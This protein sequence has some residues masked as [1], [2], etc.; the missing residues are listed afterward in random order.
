MPFVVT[1]PIEVMNPPPRSIAAPAPATSLLAKKAK[2]L[3]EQREDLR[4]RMSDFTTSLLRTRDLDLPCVRVVVANVLAGSREAITG[5]NP[6]D[7]TQ[8]L[9][10]VFDGLSDGLALLAENSQSAVEPS[11][12]AMNAARLNEMMVKLRGL[13]HSFLDTCAC[14]ADGFTD[15]A[16]KELKGFI[17]HAKTVGTKIG[18]AARTTMDALDQRLLEATRVG[19]GA[20][21][22]AMKAMAREIGSN[23]TSS[24]ARGRNAKSA[25]R[26]PKRKG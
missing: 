18:P 12:R 21:S 15:P 6:D 22:R 4:R 8:V 13:E 14:I 1:N 11:G 9:R 7:R 10:Q 16:R 25:A 23:G 26:S 17:S 5:M 20:A 24:A 19:S 2:S 3:I